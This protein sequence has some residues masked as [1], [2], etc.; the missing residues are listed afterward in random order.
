MG[1]TSSLI[2]MT[3]ILGSG[4]CWWA[5]KVLTYRFKLEPKPVCVDEMALVLFSHLKLVHAHLFVFSW[6]C[7]LK[8]EPKPVCV[9][10]RPLVL[11]SHLKLAH[12]HLFVLVGDVGLS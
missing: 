4:S 10:E 5:P 8:L 7:G 3:N 6:K 9:D 11:F 12:G 2:F 1:E